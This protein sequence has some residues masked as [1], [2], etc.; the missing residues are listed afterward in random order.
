MF[1]KNK[2]K[3]SRTFHTSVN[4]TMSLFLKECSLLLDNY[5]VGVGVLRFE[6]GT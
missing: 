4:S 3:V 6:H 1:T 5:L 2:S